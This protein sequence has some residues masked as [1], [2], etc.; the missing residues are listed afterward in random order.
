VQENRIRRGQKILRSPPFQEGEDRLQAARAEGWPGRRQADPAGPGLPLDPIA[1]LGFGVGGWSGVVQGHE[2]GA[3]QRVLAGELEYG[4]TDDD[5]ARGYR[6]SPSL[7]KRRSTCSTSPWIAPAVVP[8]SSAAMAS[9]M[10]SA[11]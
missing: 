9:A 2:G 6:S 4:G 3:G 7:A 1:Q 5:A 11:A 8:S 10:A